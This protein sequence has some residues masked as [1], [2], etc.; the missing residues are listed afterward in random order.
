M[1]HNLGVVRQ[2]QATEM[3]ML[4]WTLDPIGFGTRASRIAER[5]REYL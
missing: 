3:R 4:C 1:Y 2:V 5:V